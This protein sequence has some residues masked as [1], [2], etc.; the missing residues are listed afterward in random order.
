MGKIQCAL[1]HKCVAAT[2]KTLSNF[3]F[4]LVL[5]TWKILWLEDLIFLVLWYDKIFWSSTMQWFKNHLQNLKLN[6]EFYRQPV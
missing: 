6:S 2:E 4:N 1:V 3:D 5:G